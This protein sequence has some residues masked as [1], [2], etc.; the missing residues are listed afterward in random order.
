[1]VLTGSEKR[2]S[3]LGQQNDLSKILEKGKIHKQRPCFDI[4]EESKK[5]HGEQETQQSRGDVVEQCHHV[6]RER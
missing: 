6:A 1:M 5:E 3:G 2:D 4:L